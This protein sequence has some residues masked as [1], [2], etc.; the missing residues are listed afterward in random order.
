MFMLFFILPITLL[1]FVVNFFATVSEFQREPFSIWKVLFNGFYREVYL[2]NFAMVFIYFMLTF[3][4]SYILVTVIMD[5]RKAMKRV[6][7]S[8]KREEEKKV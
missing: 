5:T 1:G 6:S 3:Y 7:V 8:G 2:D 4:F